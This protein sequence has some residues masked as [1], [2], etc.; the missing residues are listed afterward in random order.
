[1]PNPTAAMLVIGWAQD[2]LGTVRL[3]P[4]YQVPI[5][6]AFLVF[7]GAGSLSTMAAGVI[8]LAMTT[9]ANAT[10]PNAFWAEVYGTAHI[11]SI[12][13]AVAAVMVLGSAIGPGVTGALID[14][15]LGLERQFVLIAGYFALTTGMITL[16]AWRAAAG[17]RG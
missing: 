8:L 14:A 16:A 11:G 13:A 7:A 1:M 5:L 3:M 9:G 4:F 2:R 15:G 17:L 6:L 10:L 12:K